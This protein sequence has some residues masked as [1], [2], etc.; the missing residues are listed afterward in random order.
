MNIAS[1]QERKGSKRRRAGRRAADQRSRNGRTGEGQKK[2][3]HFERIATRN[4]SPEQPTARND[5]PT[6]SVHS[7]CQPASVAAATP[8][9]HSTI[10]ATDCNSSYPNFTLDTLIAFRHQ[11]SRY[12]RPLDVA[13]STQLRIFD[14]SDLSDGRSVNLECQV[15]SVSTL[16]YSRKESNGC[17][18]ISHFL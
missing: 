14:E 4:G 18:M 12:F 9:S 6:Q 8:A 3:E 2:G 10:M 16:F 11:L 5:R 15:R 17:I 1:W 13:T 7:L